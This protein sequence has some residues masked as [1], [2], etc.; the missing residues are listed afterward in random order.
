MYLE[1]GLFF[2]YLF[3]CICS[4]RDKSHLDIGI[5]SIDMD[6]T[7]QM[8]IQY[9]YIYAIRKQIIIRYIYTVRSKGSRTEFFYRFPT[10]A[11]YRA[12]IELRS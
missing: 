3:I 10:N 5:V 1:I 7:R 9:E 4:I 11:I 12:A 6:A 2:V 8:Y